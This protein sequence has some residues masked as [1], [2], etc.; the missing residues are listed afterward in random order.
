M[1]G[2]LTCDRIE[3]YHDKGFVIIE[4]FLD[5]QDVT[6]PIY[7]AGGQKPGWHE[8]SKCRAP[9][10]IGIWASLRCRVSNPLNSAVGR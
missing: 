4:D 7:A 9:M 10:Y 5:D 1:N 2:N 8:Q 6:P 3:S